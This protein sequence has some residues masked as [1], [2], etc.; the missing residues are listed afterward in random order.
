MGEESNGSALAGWMTV[1]GMMG[2]EDGC[3]CGCEGLP[4]LALDN[5]VVAV[6]F[7]CAAARF[8]CDI[9]RNFDINF[10]TG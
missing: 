1:S 5:S 2:N 10:R 6:V 9:F 4:M 7:V 3:D 8:S